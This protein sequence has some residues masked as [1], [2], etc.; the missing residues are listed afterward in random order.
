MEKENEI[1]FVTHNKG[2]IASAQKYI[3]K[4]KLIPYEHELIEP[5]SDDIT[6][7]ATSKVKQAYE[8]VKRHWIA[9]DSGFYIVNYPK[10]I[11]IMRR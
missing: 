2:K 4:A 7:I 5:R 10:R 3:K 11:R 6:E 1:V 9:Q 8:L